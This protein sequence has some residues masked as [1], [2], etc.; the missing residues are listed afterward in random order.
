MERDWDVTSLYS[1]FGDVPGLQ[2]DD[3]DVAP[4]E[5]FAQ[6]MITGSEIWFD[7]TDYLESV[8]NGAADFGLAVQS[9]GSAD[10]WQIHLNGSPESAFRPRLV[11]VSDLAAVPPGLAG[12]FNDDGSVDAADYVIWRKNVGTSFDL[13]GNGDETGPSA[14]VVDQADYALWRAKFGTSAP[15]A[16]A[17]AAAV[18]EP[19]SWLL[20]CAAASVVPLVTSRKRLAL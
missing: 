4:S 7:V 18:P 14:G 2:V 6:G 13:N 16:A 11:V 17:F 9:T 15:G 20:I 5:F 1:N 12:D 10:G 3:N 19:A 8:R